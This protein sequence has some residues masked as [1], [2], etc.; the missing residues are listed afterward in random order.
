VIL[1]PFF[2]ALVGEL[3]VRRD[4]QAAGRAGFGAALGFVLATVAKLALAFAM[5]GIFLVVRFL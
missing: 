4:L 2:G 5:V 1:G 3:M